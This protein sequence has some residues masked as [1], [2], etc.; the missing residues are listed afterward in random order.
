[1]KCLILAG[2][3]SNRMWPVSRKNYPKQFANLIGEHSLFQQAIVRNMPFCDEF[4]ITSSASYKNII[5]GQLQSFPGLKYRTF[6]EETDRLTAPIVLFACLI[7]DP[8]EDFIVVSSDNFIQSGDYKKVIL[9]AK[10]IIEKDKLVSFGIDSKNATVGVGFF[11]KSGD[12]R[13]SYKTADNHLEL[14]FLSENKDW[15]VDAGILMGKANVF[16]R[17]LKKC[18]PELYNAVLK[19]KETVDYKSSEIVITEEAFKDVKRISLATGLTVKSENMEIVKGEFDCKRIINLES[20]SLLL[21]DDQRGD[22]IQYNCNNVDIINYSDNQVVVVNTLDDL[23]IVNTTDAVYISK[24]GETDNIKPIILENQNT[25]YSKRFEETPI[26]YATW[27]KRETLAEDDNYWVRKLT[28]YAGRALKNNKYK[29]RSKSWFILSG[30]AEALLDDQLIMMEAGDN[31]YIKKGQEHQL[32]NITSKDLVVVE[33]TY[34]DEYKSTGTIELKQD[35]KKSIVKM[36]PEPKETIW[37]GNRLSQIYGKKTDGRN[38]AE[39]WEVSAHPNGQ[40]VIADG[41]YK[42]M[43]FGDYLK[44][45]GRESLGWK[46]QF[47][48]RFPLLVKFIDATDKLS[49]QVHPNNDYAMIVEDEYGK[50]EMWYI[51]D[52]APNAY[53]YCGLKSGVT[54][55]DVEIGIRDNTLTDIMNKVYVKKGEAYF[56]PA[57]TVHAIGEGILLCEIQQNS[58]VTYRLYD[59]GRVDQNGKKRALHISKALDVID[60]NGKM[61]CFKNSE[62][63]SR[64][65]I[66][67]CKYFT[68]TRFVSNPTALINTGSSSFTVLIVISGDG[69]IES[70]DRAINFKAGESFF[71]PA[72]NGV[73]KIRGRAEI[74]SV[75]I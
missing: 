5:D 49:V 19:A 43:T 71:V 20:L 41:E 2:G 46:G 50:N 3:P 15:L 10:E 38:I 55:E 11:C 25:K 61:V 31:I 24:N 56:I 4:W 60:Y 73:I 69:I 1:M 40:S 74:L 48:D 33:T 62:I 21:N 64:D 45:V 30:K 72:K 63:R 59:Y 7:A 27:G 36:V 28:I 57:G 22:S 51:I 23:S 13:L 34:G 8:N 16:A 58:D 68:V 53:I 44:I 75:K 47:Y 26:L 39:S 70:D 42:G 6:Y 52:A 12:G 54:K 67:E 37:G 32:F 66:C 29:S 65:V 18:E 9:E 35:D 14:K 17:E